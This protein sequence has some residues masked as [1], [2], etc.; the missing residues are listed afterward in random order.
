MVDVVKYNRICVF[1]AFVKIVENRE[2]NVV[3]DKI[4]VY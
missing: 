4:F 3:K 1:K 2:V